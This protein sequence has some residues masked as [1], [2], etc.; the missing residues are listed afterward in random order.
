MARFSDVV[1]KVRLWGGRVADKAAPIIIA[2]R[3][4]GACFA[5]LMLFAGVFGI[6]RLETVT[7]YRAFVGAN[8]PDMIATDWLSSR[9][10]GGSEVLTILYR[11]GDKNIYSEISVLAYSQLATDAR[12]IPHVREAKSL[13][14]AVMLAQPDNSDAAQSGNYKIV[15]ILHPMGFFGDEARQQLRANANA[16]PSVAGRY[17]PKDGSSALISLALDATDTKGGKRAAFDAIEA[18]VAK[19]ETELQK[20]D[21]KGQVSLVGAALFDRASLGIIRSDLRVLV[22]IGLIFFFVVSFVMFRTLG[23]SF[24]VLALVAASAASA[25]GFAA[26]FGMKPTI[27]AFSALLLIAT[28]TVSEASHVIAAYATA[29]TANDNKQAALTQAIRDNFWPITATTATDA[30]GYTALLY[31]ASPAVRDMGLLVI[32]GLVVGYVFILTALPFLALIAAQ[33]K[34]IGIL[35]KSTGLFESLGA[36]SVRRYRMVLVCIA[37][38]SAVSV[39]GAAQLKSHDSIQGWFGAETSFRQDLDTLSRDYQSLQ[40]FT[41]AI[42][43]KAED[44]VAAGSDATR[45]EQKKVWERLDNSLHEIDGLKW[46]SPVD[47]AKAAKSDVFALSPAELTP[48]TEGLQNPSFSSLA[49]VGLATPFEPGRTNFVLWS[50][51]AFSLSNHELSKAASEVAETAS[52]QLTDRET[53]VSGLGLVFA[54]LGEANLNGVLTGSFMSLAIMTLCLIVTFGSVRLGLVSLLPNLIPIL[55]V[56]GCVGWAGG[57]LNLAT[58]TVFSVALGIIVNDNIHIFMKY[59]RAKLTP[60]ADGQAIVKTVST[61]GPAVAVSSITLAGGFFILANSSFLLTAHKAALV[62]ACILVAAILD[63]I[64]TPA[65]LRAVEV[66]STKKTIKDQTPNLALPN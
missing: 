48:Q 61:I 58:V 46:Y 34:S 27:L 14:D 33:P 42:E 63:V 15:P 44:T 62:G 38:M 2:R 8:D 29:L 25:F 40:G 36:F 20:D 3:K 4:L 17:V 53:Q 9:T 7:D 47:I 26:L 49:A 28:L 41:L 21:P 18:S 13:F 54:R 16:S 35:V 22:P 39:G 23:Q 5:L 31:S 50:A 19:L 64:A 24:V 60:A 37:L 52:Q 11:P 10:H 1:S 56:F 32:F 6:T 59:Q 66:L 55:W 57:Q 30:I 51:D 65:L 45:L 43:T 12:Y